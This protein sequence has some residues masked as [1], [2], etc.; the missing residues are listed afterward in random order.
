MPAARSERYQVVAPYN[1]PGMQRRSPAAAGRLGFT[2]D[3]KSAVGGAD[4]FL[5]RVTDS[6]GLSDQIQINVPLPSPPPPVDTGDRGGV[7]D[8][9]PHHLPGCG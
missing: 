8:G 6:S 4:A 3:L 7:G 2:T 1:C 5:V 9:I